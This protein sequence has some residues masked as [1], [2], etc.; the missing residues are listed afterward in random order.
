MALANVAASLGRMPFRDGPPRTLAEAVRALA[1][2]SVTARDG[3][4]VQP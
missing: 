2:R 1:I 4:V 3:F